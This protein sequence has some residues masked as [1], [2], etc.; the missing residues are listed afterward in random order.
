MRL[1]FVIPTS[2]V[3]VF[4]GGSQRIVQVL[5]RLATRHEVIVAGFWRSEEQRA[6]LERFG[7]ELNIRVEP[8]AFERMHVNSRLP[9]VLLRRARARFGHLPADV[10]MWDQPQ[11]HRAIG[12]I[13]ATHSP[14]LLQAEYP[15]LAPYALA[16]PTL[17]K[18]LAIYEVPSI[19]F[20]D[21]A[22][23]AAN[24]VER[25]RL[26]RQASAWRDYESAVCP[27]FDLTV[28]V[29]AEDAGVIEG[30]A[31]SARVAVWPNG[32]DT[33]ALQPG[34]IR[35]QA[36]RLLFVG[37]PNHAPNIDGACWLLRE[38]W[39]VL[40][41]RHPDLRLTLTNMDTQAV[42][43]CAQPGVEITGRLPD[44]T[45]EYRRADIALAPLRAGAGTRLKVL[46]AFAQ[47]VPVVS[48]SI[49]HKGLQAVPGVH[50]LSADTVNDF[51]AA[52][53]RLLE[54]ADLRRRLADSARRLV[55]EQYDWDR[56]AELHEQG[57]GEVLENRDLKSL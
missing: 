23:L 47:G 57:F 27:Q 39:P 18:T 20:G 2:P 22:D 5:R 40:R 25:T 38:I 21:Q 44:L 43:A 3:P 17:P 56:I 33:K 46:E 8:V 36:N 12:Q 35:P 50:L 31:P 19:H 24:N 51:V 48:T 26:R 41:A 15:Y 16:Q 13:I 45:P 4:S 1:L 49:G 6:G 14:H 28:T 34:P 54:S 53:Q 9:A 42:R 55:E 7:E 37:S 10:V 30:Q 11:M 52:I 29:S 32:V